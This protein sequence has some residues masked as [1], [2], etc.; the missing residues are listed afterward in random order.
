MSTKFNLPV[1]PPR[2]HGT[3]RA[4][5]LAVALHVLLAAMVI[6][7]AGLSHH[8]AP[9]GTD[10]VIK[11][12]GTPL[13]LTTSA[14]HTA[15]PASVSLVRTPSA[16]LGTVNA[17]V[18]VARHLHGITIKPQ[19]LKAPALRISAI[20]AR[21]PRLPIATTVTAQADG[22]IERER[23][24]RLAAL[25]DIAGGPPPKIDVAASQDYAKTVARRVRANVVVPFEIPGNPSAVIAVTCAPSGALLSVRMQR[26]S[27]NPQWD[28]AVLAAVEKSDPMP[29]DIDG[30]TPAS[31]VLTFQPKG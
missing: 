16:E 2:E 28:R 1:W 22:E 15:N 29:R 19:R 12:P 23:T 18:P 6:S 14:Q 25:Q 3:G 11:A 24:A 8:H 9:T 10:T 30:A 21:R 13:L 20:A 31:I 26:S 7:S 27:G 17:L 5:G 4:F